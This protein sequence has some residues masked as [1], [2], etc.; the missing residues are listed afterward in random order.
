VKIVQISDT[1]LPAAGGAIASNLERVAGFVNHRLKPDLIVHTGDVV[2]LSPDSPTDREFAL[3][4]HEAFEAPVLFLPGNHDVGEPGDRPWMGL[5][6][7]SER[8][9]AH[10]S[11]FGPDHFADRFGCW[12]SIGLNS[13][14]F[15]SG[16][17]EEEEQWEWLTA[18]LAAVPSN[19]HVLLF[20]HMP[21]W[22][23]R[24][25]PSDDVS[26]CIPEYSRERLLALPGSDRI[27]ATASGHL[28]RYRRRPRPDLIEV[29]APST[30]F[31]GQTAT[32]VPHFEQLGVVE[33]QL[34][35]DGL[36]VWFRAPTDLDE[37]E[38]EKI[39]ELVN[40]RESLRSSMTEVPA[41]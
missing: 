30:A 8:V 23:P 39:P 40:S 15:G 25:T 36:G 20:L 5:A 6:V 4:A 26:L 1:H 10:C 27:R 7:S 17:P 34:N 19:G 28:H 31:V 24:A 14:L 3:A 38:G 16:L 35:A 41:Q 2:A 21:L 32:E 11:V 22:M 18:T 13:Q 29:W 37:R 33:W 12:T 9:T